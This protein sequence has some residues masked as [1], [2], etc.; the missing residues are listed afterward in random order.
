MIGGRMMSRI[1]EQA[2]RKTKAKKSYTLSHESIVFLENT[3]KKRRGASVSS[4]LDEMIQNAR[5]DQE[6]QSLNQAVEAY[7]SGLSGHEAQEMEEWGNFAMRQ[8]PAEDRK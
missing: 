6:R 4:V 7:Y 5:R 8:F 1:T 3:S 2:N